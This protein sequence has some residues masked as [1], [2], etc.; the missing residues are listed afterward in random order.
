MLFLIAS[1]FEYTRD[2]NDSLRAFRLEVRNERFEAEG[3]RC[4]GGGPQE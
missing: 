1:L 2:V 3:P 4:A